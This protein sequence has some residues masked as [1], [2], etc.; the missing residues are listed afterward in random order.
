MITY[1]TNCFLINHF[2]QKSVP[3]LTFLFRLPANNRKP[4]R[5]LDRWSRVLPSRECFDWGLWR[6]HI[7]ELLAGTRQWSRPGICRQQKLPGYDND[8]CQTEKHKQCHRCK[9]PLLINPCV[10]MMKNMHQCGWSLCI[11]LYCKHL[12]SNQRLCHLCLLWHDA[13]GDR[14]GGQP[15]VSSWHVLCRNPGIWAR[16]T[17]ARAVHQIH[18]VVISSNYRRRIAIFGVWRRQVGKQQLVDFI[19]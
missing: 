19:I 14:L 17:Q 8:S 7:H 12:Q 10:T 1:H 3:N 11:L 4:R 2:G 13:L 6:P 15:A 5:F 16:N 9:V 18:V